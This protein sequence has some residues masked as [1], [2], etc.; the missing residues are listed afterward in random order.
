MTP[1]E[2]PP[3]DSYC[4]QDTDHKNEQPMTVR[5][6]WALACPPPFLPSPHHTHVHCR[7]T[8]PPP[9]NTPEASEHCPHLLPGMIFLFLTPAPPPIPLTSQ[10]SPRSPSGELSL[11]SDPHL[12]AKRLLLQSVLLQLNSSFVWM[13]LEPVAFTAS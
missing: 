8:S 7:Y 4:L 1:T 2:N 6:D 3:G 13:D 11:T 10:W 12:R 9:P 5:L